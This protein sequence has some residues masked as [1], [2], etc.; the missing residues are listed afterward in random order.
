MIK[1]TNLHISSSNKEI[2]FKKLKLYG[3]CVVKNYFSE[4]NI[5]SLNIDYNNLFLKEAIEGSV[6]HDHPINKDGKFVRL[7]SNDELRN[8]YPNLYKMFHSD[9]M[10]DIAQRYFGEYDYILNSDIFLSHEKPSDKPLL[11]W[12]FDRINS[13][14]FYT[15]LEDTD[16]TNGAFEYVPGSHREGY[17]RSNYFISQGVPIEELPNDIPDDE[18]VNPITI[19]AKAGDLLIFNPDGFHKGGIVSEGKERKVIRGHTFCH[20]MRSYG[21]NKDPEFLTDKSKEL[22]ELLKYRIDNF[23]RVYDSEFMSQAVTR[24]KNK[25]I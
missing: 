1:L 17:F 5:K 14:K 25:N 7:K 15:Y 24:D 18:I 6:K 8:K 2:I 3:I 10:S 23:G 11:P 16:K 21:Y 22:N 20:P 12:H 9:F 13:L 19:N 4:E